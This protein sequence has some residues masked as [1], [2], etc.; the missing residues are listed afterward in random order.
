MPE[1][2]VEYQDLIEQLSISPTW[3]Q[4]LASLLGKREEDLTQDDFRDYVPDGQGGIRFVP[5]ADSADSD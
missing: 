5:G 3:G 4:C 1:K 2:T